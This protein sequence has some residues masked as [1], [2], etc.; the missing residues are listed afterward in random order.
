MHRHRNAD[1]PPLRQRR[2]LW[3]WPEWFGRSLRNRYLG[4]IKRQIL[5]QQRRLRHRLRK[6]IKIRMRRNRTHELLA[7]RVS[8]LPT[9]GVGVL[10]KH[11][12]PK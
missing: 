1:R 5:R 12:V 2:K 11:E 4:G 10:Q 7:H 9:N 8:E 3:Q 6:H